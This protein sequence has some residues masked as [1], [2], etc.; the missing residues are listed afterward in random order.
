MTPHCDSDTI[1]GPMKDLIVGLKTLALLSTVSLTLSCASGRKTP[2]PDPVLPLSWVALGPAGTVVVR[3]LTREPSCPVLKTDSKEVP[4]QARIGHQDRPEFEIRICETVLDRSVQRA[5]IDGQ[6]LSLPK[7][8]PERIVIIGDTGCR[9]KTKKGN[10][11]WIQDC[12][13]PEAWPFQRIAEAAAK[14]N[15][16][17]V[18]HTGDYLYRESAC[19]NGAKGCESFPSGDTFA[20]WSADFL[21]P[22]RSLLTRAP[23]IFVRGN[24]ESCTRTG[25]GFFRLLD[26]NPFNPVCIEEP[27]PYLIPFTNARFAVLDTSLKQVHP[28]RLRALKPLKLVS[29]V[30]LTHRPLWGEETH[31]PLGPVPGVKLI[32]A[33]HWHLFHLSTFEDGRAMQVVVGNSGTELIKN[34]RQTPTGTEVDGTLLKESNLIPGFGFTLLERVGNHWELQA[35]DTTGQVKMRKKIRLTPLL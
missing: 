9:V 29:D 34:P 21:T 12:S 25:E 33:G 8:A 20:A 1:K 13:N 28:E 19:P 31:V 24:H 7:N 3:H 23:W 15:P 16:D 2:D 14:L 35:R 32:F 11:A 17:L 4:L 6:P 10:P 5:E 18:I 27:E 30:L 26:P 22:A